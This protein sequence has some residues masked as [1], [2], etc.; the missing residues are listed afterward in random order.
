MYSKPK[1]WSVLILIVIGG[2]NNNAAAAQS[3][4]SQKTKQNTSTK[5]QAT[6]AKGD[7]S[8]QPIDV[9]TP[10]C[11]AYM[12]YAFKIGTDNVTKKQSYSITEVFDPSAISNDQINKFLN[13][14]Q[15][16]S[17]QI[18]A[19]ESF[20]DPGYPILGNPD[21]KFL[22]DGSDL[23]RLIRRLTSVDT[24]THK[25]P[26]SLCPAP[27][28]T[29]VTPK[30]DPL[31]QY[32]LV[33]IVRWK[34]AGGAYQTD[35]SDW[36]LFNRSD[37]KAA[38]REFPFTFHPVVNGGK[39]LRIFGSDK[40][41][42]L[43]IHLAPEG[44]YANFSQN[45]KLQY[46]LAVTKLE[47]ANIQDFKALI[48]VITGQ[49]GS[50]GAGA[51]A[52]EVPA[53]PNFV[54]Y[55]QLLATYGSRPYDG[56][57]AAAAVTNL[58]SL[59]VQIAATMNATLPKVDAALAQ[60][61]VYEDK[62]FWDRLT[63]SSG[64]VAP[65]SGTPATGC[66]TVGNTGTCPETL[67]VQNEG[68]YWWDVSIGVPFKGVRQL[69]FDT[70]STGQVTPRTISKGSAYG[71][72]V[73]APWKEDIVSPPSLG[74]PHI[75]IGLPLSGKVFDSPFVG[76]GET[77]NLSKL[78]S[79]GDKLSKVIPIGIRLYAGLVENKEFGPP[80]TSGTSGP[81]SHWVGKLQYGIEF[82]VRDVASKLTSKKSTPST[83]SK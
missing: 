59:P 51:G 65:A 67:T 27:S 43:A 23:V 17:G 13:K 52:E 53:N 79:I 10:Y 12:P 26:A 37:P 56:L 32:Y 60:E 38:H 34:R 33:N 4:Q 9:N 22:A 68:L 62:G 40:V 3:Q 24:T 72:V 81:P 11:D 70:S 64:S 74:I 5:K 16:T 66:S 41:F 71:F 6:P 80:P 35:S 25:P 54:A 55:K 1:I 20:D 63:A 45:V 78:P 49:A 58:E 15:S 83:S 44:D 75:L 31:T 77:F 14:N 21:N 48:G 2:V 57:Y 7:K 46:K 39:N 8:S 30:D 50:G 82:S 42:F 36:Y 29:S 61:P 73:L 28:T 18:G 76:L 47:P 69:Q 19:D